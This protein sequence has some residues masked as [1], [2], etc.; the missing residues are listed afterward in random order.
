MRE[1]RIEE[2]LKKEIEKMGGWCVKFPPLFFRGFPDRILL[3]PK[4]VLIFVETKS[5]TGSP[6]KIQLKVHEGLRGL[7]FRVEVVATMEQLEGF[8]ICL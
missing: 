8:L 7:G 1:S 4:G 6:T 2:K 3:M 5:P